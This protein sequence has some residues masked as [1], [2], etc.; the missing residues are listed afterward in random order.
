M[1]PNRAGL[2]GGTTATTAA[3][4]LALGRRGPRGGDSPRPP[5]ASSEPAADHG[6]ARPRA[7]PSSPPISPC[8]CA[9]TARSP[10][11]PVAPP[12]WEGACLDGFPPACADDGGPRHWLCPP[13]PRDHMAHPQ[14]K[15]AAWL[16]GKQSTTGRPP[17]S[18]HPMRREGQS[19]A[20]DGRCP[21]AQHAAHPR[22]VA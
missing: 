5:A 7:P 2:P 22:W 21:R 19:L 10:T 17:P 4:S 6:A 15:K 11:T 18:E 13:P 12:A 8:G 16:K 1:P 9:T 3:G 20:H 14:A